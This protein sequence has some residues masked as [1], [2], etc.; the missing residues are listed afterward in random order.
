[1][2]AKDVAVYWVRVEAS[3]WWRTGLLPRLSR[4]HLRASHACGNPSQL[5]FGTS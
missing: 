3:L 5:F 1:M 4:F 2:Q